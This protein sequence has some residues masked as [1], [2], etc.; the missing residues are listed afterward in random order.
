MPSDISLWQRIIEAAKAFAPGL[1]AII[2]SGAIGGVFAFMTRVQRRRRKNASGWHN[3][4]ARLTHAKVTP[5]VI[6]A[7]MLP[8]CFYAWFV[9]F[10]SVNVKNHALTHTVEDLT[11]PQFS[12]EIRQEE[13]ATVMVDA[14]NPQAPHMYVELFAKVINKGASGSVLSDSWELRI[15]LFDGR[16][17]DAEPT[18]LDATGRRICMPDGQHRQVIEKSDD[19][20]LR[21]A[22]T[23]DRNSYKDGILGFNIPAIPT[24]QIYRDET[25]FTLTAKDTNNTE[26]SIS[27]TR[28]SLGITGHNVFMPSL[29]HPRDEPGC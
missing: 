16:I 22:N 13:M 23:I 17:I 9:S 18:T 6:W 24:D 3:F 2:T 29:S 7:I 15:K 10:D 5:H 25:E 28:G 27:V 4:L 21:A 26:F 20:S 1:W 19:L 8:G 12:I 11:R 14:N